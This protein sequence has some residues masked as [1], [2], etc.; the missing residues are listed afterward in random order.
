MFVTP[1]DFQQVYVCVKLEYMT[2]A[3][4]YF[5]SLGQCFGAGFDIQSV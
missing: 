3:V 5:L 2:M 1:G 4:R